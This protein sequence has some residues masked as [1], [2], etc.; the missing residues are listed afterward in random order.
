M[1]DHTTEN[2]R[3]ERCKYN[4]IGRKKKSEKGY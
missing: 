4:Q 1:N 3:E 2:K